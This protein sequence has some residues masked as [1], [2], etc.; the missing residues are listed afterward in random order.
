MCLVEDFGPVGVAFGHSAGGVLPLAA[1]ASA[2]FTAINLPRPVRTLDDVQCDWSG[3]D[4]RA[5]VIPMD[6]TPSFGWYARNATVPSEPEGGANR[7]WLAAAVR[8]EG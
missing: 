6:I 4:Q 3:D 8:D 5:S 2:A 1:L 7:G